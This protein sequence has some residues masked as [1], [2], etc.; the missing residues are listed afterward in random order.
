MKK[1]KRYIVTENQLPKI[2]HYINENYPAGIN[3]FNIDYLSG[4]NRHSYDRLVDATLKENGSLVLGISTDRDKIVEK[5]VWIG[6]DHI[7]QHIESAVQKKG[8]DIT[9]FPEWEVIDAS[10]NN[11]YLVLNIG[12]DSNNYKVIV[13]WEEIV[14]WLPELSDT[15]L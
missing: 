12:G 1:H 14:K 15:D 8:Y 9:N 2:I 5:E 10:V 3:D 11:G 7:I 13:G 6:E 4:A